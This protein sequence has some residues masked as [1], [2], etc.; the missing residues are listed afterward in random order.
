MRHMEQFQREGRE[1]QANSCVVDTQMVPVLVSSVIDVNSD[2]GVK[3]LKGAAA[4]FHI[5]A[6]YD[7][8]TEIQQLIC[9]HKDLFIRYF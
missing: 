2:I 7:Y 9:S 5:L 4:L 3:Q 6:D 1:N 8:I